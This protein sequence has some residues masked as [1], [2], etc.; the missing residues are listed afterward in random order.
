[1]LPAVIILLLNVRTMSGLS[2]LSF[3]IA[4]CYQLTKLK[5]LY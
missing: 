1:M 3:I 5:R 4:G 2:G